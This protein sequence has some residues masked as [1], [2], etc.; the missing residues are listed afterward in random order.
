MIPLSVGMTLI[1][2]IPMADSIAQ[3]CKKFKP[4]H[5]MYGPAFW[6]AFADENQ[7][8]D[9]SYFIAPISGGDT[10]RENIENKINDYLKNVVVLIS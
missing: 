10:L 7:K 8:L 3:L 9:L 1:V 4:N 2:R 5:I 6:E